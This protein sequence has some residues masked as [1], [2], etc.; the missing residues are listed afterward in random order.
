MKKI[1]Y[2]LLRDPFMNKGTAFTLE[3]RKENGLTGLLPPA[4]ETIDQQADRVYAQYKSEHP[5]IEKRRYLMEIFN[6]NRTL[7]FHAFRKHVAEWM[8]VVYDPVIAESIETY[9]DKYVKPQYAAFLSI[10]HPEEIEET[11]KKAA[12]GRKIKLIVVTD[13]EAILG[14]GDWG[15]NGVDISIGKLMVYTA[16]AGLDPSTVLPVVLDCGTDRK[17]L[18]DDPMYLGNSHPRVRNASYDAFVDRFVKAVENEFPGVYLHFEDFGREHAAE[19]LEKYINDYPVFNDDRQGTGIITLAGLIGAMHISGKNLTDQVYMCFGAGT[20]GCGIVTRIWREMMDEGLSEE[21]ARSRFYMVDKQGLLFD[22]MDDLTPE[23]KPFARKRSEFEHPEALTT[24]EAAVEAIHPTILVSASEACDRAKMACDV[25]RHSYMSFYNIFDKNLLEKERTR[26]FVFLNIGDALK[27]HEIEVYYQPQVDARTGKLCGAEGLARWNSPKAGFMMPGKF[28][29]VLEAANLTYKLDIYIIRQIARDFRKCI[30]E[31]TPIVP[32]SF[33]FS[34]TDFE[35]CNPYEELQ[36]AVKEYNLEPKMFRVEITEST[37]MSDPAKIKEQMTLFRKAGYEV[38]M[39]D[40]GSAYSSLATLRDFDFDEIKID[41]GFMR[42][43]SDK[44]KKIIR[45]MIM[46]AQSLDVHTLTEGVE[47]AEQ[48]SFLQQAGCERIQ[49][50][51]FS[52]P[53][54]Y[55]EFVQKLKTMDCCDDLKDCEK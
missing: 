41:M 23:Q 18:L 47:T 24:L 27:N 9:S 52:K 7:F 48:L 11:L 43:F 25:D 2:D 13:A 29:P 55:S 36:K 1:G 50:Y 5:G 37:L 45:P 44:S 42:N 22:D 30:E 3:E 28:I 38:L 4:V 16:A 54:P 17:E 40:F 12:E 8:P 6:D 34:R 49:G 33:N 53:I 14:I 19:I 21:E 46:L 51:Y 15:V 10:D 31:G 26:S 39:D 32:V 35:T 20:A